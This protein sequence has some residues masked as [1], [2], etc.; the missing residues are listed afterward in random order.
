MGTLCVHLIRVFQVIGFFPGAAGEGAFRGPSG[1]LGGF[2]FRE[3]GF[4]CRD[5]EEETAF[6]FGGFG[7]GCD[8]V[9]VDVGCGDGGVD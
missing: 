1:R 6:D 9:D 4:G 7:E 2:D 5:A 8:L 3:A